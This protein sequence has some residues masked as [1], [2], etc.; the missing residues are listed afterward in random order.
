VGIKI[1]AI[2]GSY[3][4]NGMV[5]T[6]V[7]EMLAALSSRGAEVDK[8]YLI[9]QRIEYCSNCQSCTQEEGEARGTCPI[10][11]DMAG[12]LDKI[13][14]SDALILASPMN[15][16]TV[17][18]LMKCFIERLICYGYWPWEMNAPKPRI[19]KTTKQAV[20]VTSSAMPAVMGRCLT[21]IVKLLRDT[22]KLLGARKVQS[23]Y[24]GLA[25]HTPTSSLSDRYKAKARKLA[26]RLVEH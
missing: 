3:H 4:K 24:I 5:D 8:V 10:E 19:K 20:V 26:N 6:A 16:G 11:D 21:G 23:L 25:R 14:A 7:D 1:T 12:I 15:C 22:A 9:D 17:T 13:D 18:A 2:V